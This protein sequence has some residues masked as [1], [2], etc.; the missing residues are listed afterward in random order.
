MYLK[1]GYVVCMPD[2]L[3]L[4]KLAKKEDVYQWPEE[5]EADSWFVHFACGQG[6][7]EKF[8]YDAPIMKPFLCWHRFKEKNR[9]RLHIVS[10]PKFISKLSWAQ[11]K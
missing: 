10:T 9:E 7:L 8:I 5:K 11:L 2:R 6:A 4:A 3:I 1:H